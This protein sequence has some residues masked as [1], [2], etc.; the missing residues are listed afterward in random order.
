MDESKIIKKTVDGWY[1]A[2]N[3]K[4][5]EIYEL[6]R[7]LEAAQEELDEQLIALDVVY[8]KFG[9]GAI[10]KREPTIQI[11]DTLLHQE[12]Y[13]NAPYISINKSG[14]GL[15]PSIIFEGYRCPTKVKNV[16]LAVAVEGGRENQIAQHA[17]EGGRDE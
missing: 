2:A 8:E 13:L 12:P 5:S 1:R 9:V 17:V 15:K 16:L 4:I 3:E 11:Y 14:N 7:K 10:I 6:T